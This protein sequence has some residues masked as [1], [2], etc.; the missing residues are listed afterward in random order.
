MVYFKQRVSPSG[1]TVAA[2]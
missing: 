2:L 1:E